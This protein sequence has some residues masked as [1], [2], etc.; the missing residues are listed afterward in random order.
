[1]CRSDDKVQ[2]RSMSMPVNFGGFG[3][4]KAPVNPDADTDGAEEQ[5]AMEMER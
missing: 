5:P 3:K 4:K 2:T 1:M